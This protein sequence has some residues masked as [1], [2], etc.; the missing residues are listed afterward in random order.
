MLTNLWWIAFYVSLA[1]NVYGW[2]LTLLRII[3]SIE[4]L[5]PK[6]CLA[7]QLFI[8]VGLVLAFIFG[9]RYGTADNH[10]RVMWIWSASL[11]L[12]CALGLTEMPVS[13]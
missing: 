5:F 12:F 3:Q 13:R 1:G 11:L 7:A 6:L 2:A 10:R 9:W 8:P 4:D